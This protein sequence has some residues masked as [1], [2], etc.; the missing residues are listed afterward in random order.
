[1]HTANLIYI[2]PMPVSLAVLSYCLFISILS[3]YAEAFLTDLS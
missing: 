1:M 3:I 2:G